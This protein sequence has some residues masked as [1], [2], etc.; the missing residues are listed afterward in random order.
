MREAA[1]GCL[2]H[3][4]WYLTAGNGDGVEHRF[5]KGMLSEFTWL[6]ADFLLDG[7]ISAVLMLKL[8]E[9]DGGAVFGLSFAML[10]QCQARLRMPLSAVDQNVWMLG[11]EGALLKRLCVHQ[12]VELANVD[13]MQVVLERFGPKPSRWC[14]T[15]MRASVDEPAMLA[16]PLLPKGP[17]ID[18]IGQSML[19]EWPAKTPSG[20]V[21][22]HRM[23]KQ[24]DEAG[25]AKWPD[26]FSNWGG[27]KG[28]QLGKTGF[29]HAK[30]DG[31]RWW[32]VDPDGYAFWSAG[33]DC[34]KPL[35]E[36][37]VSGIEKAC[38]WLP[39]RH[40]PFVQAWRGE[41]EGRSLVNFL[42]SNLIR[43]FG[44]KWYECWSRIAIAHLK[45]VGFNTVANWSDWKMAQS[46][47]FPYVRP[48]EFRPRATP[49]IFRDFPDVYAATMEQDVAEYAAQLAEHAGDRAFIGYFLMN[50]PTWGFASETPAE[51]MLFNTESCATR[52]ALATHL[53][54]LYGTDERLRRAWGMDVSFAAVARSR[55]HGKATEAC[56]EDL[57]AFSTAM[58]DR[59]FTM[60]SS[61]CKKVDP[62]HINLGARY[63]TV[64][65]DWAL[66]GMKSFDVFSINCYRQQVPA[67]QLHKI[68]DVTGRPTLIG[69]W[70]F[71][72]LDVGLPGSGIGHVKTQADRGKAYRVY[73]EN[74]AAIP[75]CVGVHWFTMY[76]QSAIGRFDGENYNIGFLDVC[77]RPYE[78]ICSAALE[79]HRR[80]YAVAEGQ[81]QAFSD[82]PEY[83][84]MLFM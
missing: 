64:P 67:E 4:A 24:L 61:A 2:E 78:E 63:Y 38:K 30:H 55:W 33:P 28:K 27:W 42:G 50:E 43:V 36:S 9:A 84:P 77:N 52:E 62:D 51:G 26:V 12:R 22:H 49:R 58:V 54:K 48:L 8:F 81:E 60:L 25:E 56:R 32:L 21:M 29:F 17:L 34:V 79:S 14:M 69:E 53:R 20:V 45:S 57:G 3:G 23:Q 82:A 47:G 46:A 1:P 75:E 80:M 74:A 39:G 83:L 15:P 35:V 31:R 66:A 68:A 73:L 6:S 41:S 10:N 5:P 37:A 59:Y 44:E 40:E 70:H 72:A 16:E 19:H 11:R 76:D 18:A 65:P 7:N 71:G 13:R